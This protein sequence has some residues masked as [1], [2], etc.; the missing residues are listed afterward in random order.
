MSAPAI[1]APRVATVV[2][3]AREAFDSGVN[4]TLEQRRAHLIALRKLLSENRAELV[5]ALA[6]DLGKPERESALNEIDPL[7]GEITATLRNLKRWL[8]PERLPL[9]LVFRP[10]RARMVREPLGT[11][12]IISPWNYPLTLTLMPL[13]GALAAGNTAVLKPA[14]ESE[15]TAAALARLV[16]RYF[17]DGTVQVLTGP[18][19]VSTEVLTHRFDHIVFTGSGRVGRIVME[20]A[21]KHLTPVT[22]EL[23]GKS[24]VW[25][26]E[27]A[28]LKDAAHRLVWAKYTNAGQ[29]CVAPDYVMMPPH[30]IAEF[31]RHLAA[32]IRSFYGEQPLRSERYARIVHQRRFDRLVELLDQAP[33]LHG[34]GYDREALRIEP[35]IVDASGWN[36]VLSEGADVPL[37]SEEIFGPILPIV[38]VNTPREAVNIINSWDKPLALYTF[39][40]D[41]AV[42]ELFEQETSSGAIV[43]NGAVVHVG[44]GSLPFGGIGPSGMGAY[45]GRYSI[46]TF[47]HDKPVLSLPVWINPVK[48]ISPNTPNAVIKAVRFMQ[49][50]G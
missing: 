13:V 33:I 25:V 6:V 8:R 1:D 12:L 22:L 32:V 43:H 41:T 21:A 7:I 3:A 30:L 19:E 15:A 37:L 39:G 45:H 20:A 48:L 2:T 11:I 38:G 50:R 16:P 35:T 27:S 17:S 28:D 24:P 36:R 9:P 23:G 40:S 31:T 47:S 18:I 14:P 34:G 49:R 42:Q 10:A 44:V 26:D 29:T 4:A 46:E 5:R